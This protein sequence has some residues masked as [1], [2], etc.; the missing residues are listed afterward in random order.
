MSRNALKKLV[1]VDP[2]LIA[3]GGHHTGFALMAA[4]SLSERNESVELEFVCSHCI[5]ETIKA[6]LEGYG[7]R[8]KPEFHFNFYEVF[9]QEVRLA[10]VQPFIRQATLE[11]ARVIRDVE[12][13]SYGQELIFFHPSLS[14]EHAYALSL[15]LK[16]IGDQNT[17]THIVCAMFNPGI[18]H[19]GVTTDSRAK[20]QYAL[21]FRCLRS[22][23]NVKLYASD[24]ELAETYARLLN[25]QEKLPI[26]PC[27]LADWDRLYQAQRVMDG[28][29]KNTRKR[30]ILYMG[31]AK[32]DKGFYH[33]PRLI[34]NAL[35][36]VG[37]DQ[38]LYIQFSIP[39]PDTELHSV[40]MELRDLAAKYSSIVIEEGFLGEAEL[41]QLL[42]CASM[43]TFNYCSE[44]YKNKSSGFFWIV[45]WYGIPIYCFGNSWMNRESRRLGRPFLSSRGG[46]VGFRNALA[47]LRHSKNIPQTSDN[48]YWKAVY[49]SFWSWI[50]Q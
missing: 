27:Y 13:R 15:A 9:G 11:Y 19:N 32:R 50:C 17:S 33:L 7:C 48:P 44:I 34:K 31:D 4:R 14:W 22:L 41:H 2:A 28:Q 42:G 47:N 18:T 26:H 1:V 3:A 39:W 25:L 40:A 8:L 16:F 24:Y 36:S 37:E 21:G 30:V 12:E 46:M 20:M 45:A 5:D 49:R 23:A 38:E 10:E 35:K 43:F 29:G 6:E